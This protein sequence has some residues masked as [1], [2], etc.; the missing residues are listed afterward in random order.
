M[1]QKK[2]FLILGLLI[3]LT[4]A[5]V[6]T[7]SAAIPGLINYQGNLTDS[8]GTPLDDSYD[9]IFSLYDS[10]IG[11]ALLWHETQ[12]VIVTDG[13]LNVM[14]GKVTP[15]TGSEFTGTRPVFIQ[16]QIYNPDLLP[17]PDYE[18]L[19][20]RQQL[21]SIPFAL[22]AKTAETAET[23]ENADTLGGQDPTAFAEAV[24]SH[25]F[26]DLTGA[27]TDAQIPDTITV[28]HAGTAGN[29]DTLDGQDSTAFA[30]VTH[31]H[32]A[33]YV[34]EDQADSISSGMIVDGTVG[35]ADINNNA[36]TAAKV[37]PNIVS[38][39]DGVS[40]DGGNIDLIPGTNITI[41]PNDPG[42]SITIS[43]AGGASDHGA[44][45][46]LSDDDHPQY[47]TEGEGDGR[48]VNA[49]GDVINGDFTATGRIFGFGDVYVR[50][51]NGSNNDFLFMDDGTKYLSWQNTEDTFLFNN[52]LSIFGVLQTGNSITNLGYNRLGGG[53]AAYS[54]ITNASDLLV[55]DDLE[56]GDDMRV[57]GSLRAGST[58]TTYGDLFVGTNDG[59]DSDYIYMDQANEAIWWNESDNR[60]QITDD[61][62][63]GGDLET[64]GNVTA[65]GNVNTSGSVNAAGNVQTGGNVRYASP[66]TFYLQILGIDFHSLYYTIPV[67]YTASALIFGQDGGNTV[68]ASVHLPQGAQIIQARFYLY[69]NDPDTD[70]VFVGKLIRR[71]INTSSEWPDYNDGNDMIISTPNY[72]TSG[73][74]T[75]IHYTFND[76]VPAY[77]IVDNENYQ[78]ALECQMASSGYQAF[79]MQFYGVRIEYTLQTLNP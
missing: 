75:E 71:H 65:S 78:Y 26:K 4:I 17:A 7:T 34:N 40:N 24:H 36:V 30:N 21:T 28:Q 43:A 55:S 45:T 76:A 2:H 59:T 52:D 66:K 70:F 15:F 29:A 63:L 25:L 47:L 14:L 5:H 49:S 20:P 67:Q 37:A 32:D 42:N 8:S 77:S 3:L 51:N 38:S 48:Y 57:G 9:M 54:E 18:M 74:S 53:T 41:T 50:T 61:L 68:F 56:V 60:F 39:L 72:I 44:L 11:G 27:A 23:A 35:T 13:I 12:S 46:G 79:K 58:L 10:Q 69:D 22:Q 31:N 16:I 1:P 62:Y 73:A 6:S 64:T 33:A 19:S